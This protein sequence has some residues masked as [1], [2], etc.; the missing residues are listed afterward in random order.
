M[1]VILKNNN[2]KYFYLSYT[3]IICRFCSLLTLKFEKKECK[4]EVA[5]IIL[6]YLTH[7]RVF[8]SFCW[9]K[10]KYFFKSVRMSGFL[11]NSI[12]GEWKIEKWEE[13]D[14]YI[15]Y[16]VSKDNSCIYYS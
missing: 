8:S 6:E 1:N 5:K 13:K 9:C 12:V 3:N 11:N 4:T 2:V 16:Q 7:C 10:M 15:L 14:V